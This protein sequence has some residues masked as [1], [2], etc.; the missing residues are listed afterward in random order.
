MVQEREKLASEMIKIAGI[1]INTSIKNEKE[2]YFAG[3]PTG[4]VTWL[5]TLAKVLS[6]VKTYLALSKIFLS[7]CNILI[8]S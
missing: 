2:K 4:T 7:E 6:L 8:C 5:E 1:R 3:L